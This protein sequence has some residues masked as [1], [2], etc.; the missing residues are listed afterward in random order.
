MPFG[1]HQGRCLPDLILHEPQW[2]YWSYDQ[3]IL[4]NVYD[5]TELRKIVER[6]SSIKIPPSHQS[7]A[8]RV[9]DYHWENNT[10]IQVRVR[11]ETE[12]RSRHTRCRKTLDHL[13]I[14]FTLHH[15]KTRYHNAFNPVIDRVYEEH[16]PE[17]TEQISDKDAINFFTTRE[18]FLRGV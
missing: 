14:A 2:F 11:E 4:S 18:N 7:G 9:A 16:F 10:R 12:D 13:D 3:G 5:T 8:T 1:K 6:S 15:R 17:A